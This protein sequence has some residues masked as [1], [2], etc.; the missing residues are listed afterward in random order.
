M[1]AHLD[2]TSS[3]IQIQVQV[4]DLSKVCEQIVQILLASLFVNV[5]DDDDPAFNGADSGR[6]CM[7]G[8]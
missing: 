2:I 1:F 4:L 3:A 7:G 8:H 5:G 6:I